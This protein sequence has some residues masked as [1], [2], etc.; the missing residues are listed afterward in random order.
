MA[1]PKDGKKSKFF[2]DKALQSQLLGDWNLEEKIQANSSRE[3][4]KWKQSFVY[5]TRKNLPVSYSQEFDEQKD[6][7]DFE[8]D[9]TQQVVTIRWRRCCLSTSFWI[10]GLKVLKKRARIKRFVLITIGFN[11]FGSS[12]YWCTWKKK[13]FGT[14]SPWNIMIYHLD[15]CKRR[16]AEVGKKHQSEFLTLRD[17]WDKKDCVFTWFFGCIRLLI[18]VLIEEVKLVVLEEIQ[19][20]K[21]NFQK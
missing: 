1:S 8:W 2:I 20:E 3:K 19:F 21:K 18:R 5:F 9:C 10:Q 15:I 14:N 4:L 11:I 13:S 7:T 16:K 6:T 12:K 17:P